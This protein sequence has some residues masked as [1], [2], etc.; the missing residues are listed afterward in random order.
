MGKKNNIEGIRR[1]IKVA[2]TT[3]IYSEFDSIE[4]MWASL[5]TAVTTALKQNVPTKMSSTRHAHPCISTSLKRMMRRK[6]RAHRKAKKSGQSKDGGMFKR[7]Q[8]RGSAVNTYCTQ[9]IYSRCCQQRPQRE[10][11]TVLAIYQE[12]ET[13]IHWRCSTD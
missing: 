11:K 5:K 7:L 10:H 9:K 12:Q 8:V 13:G 6:Q 3:C 4:S 2:R 1:S